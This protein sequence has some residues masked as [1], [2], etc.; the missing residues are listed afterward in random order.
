VVELS[1]NGLRAFAVEVLVWFPSP[2]PFG[3]PTFPL[4]KILHVSLYLHGVLNHFHLIVFAFNRVCLPQDL[5]RVR[6]CLN[7]SAVGFDEGDVD[8]VLL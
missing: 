7:A 4:D 3:R 5:V 8:L 2:M 1:N 6:L